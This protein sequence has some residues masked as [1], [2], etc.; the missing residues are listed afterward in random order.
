MHLHAKDTHSVSLIIMLCLID[1][2]AE[3]K[4][5]CQVEGADLA[6]DAK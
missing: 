2:F 1:V 4:F 6:S 5:E 3:H